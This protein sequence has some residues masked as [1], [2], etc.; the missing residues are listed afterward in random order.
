M[1]IILSLNIINFIRYQQIIKRYYFYCFVFD[2]TVFIILF[3]SA[4]PF[5]HNA[6]CCLCFFNF[7]LAIFCSLNVVYLRAHINHLLDNFPSYFIHF[8]YAALHIASH[9]RLLLLYFSFSQD[10]IGRFF[11]FC[12]F[13]ALVPLHKRWCYS[14]YT[15]RYT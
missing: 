1:S 14:N 4:T 8:I 2:T 9:L 5:W 11:F 3:T 6:V 7:N 13:C 10:E 12:F 15:V